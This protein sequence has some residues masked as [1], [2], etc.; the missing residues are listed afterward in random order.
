MLFIESNKNLSPEIEF[1]EDVFNGVHS[2]IIEGNIR[3]IA[4]GLFKDCKT[5]TQIS[6]PPSETK[7]GDYAFSKI[8]I[9]PSVQYIGKE[10]FCD[11][12]SHT[13]ITIPPSLTFIG[14]DA[15]DGYSSLTQI[16]ISPNLE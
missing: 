7:I 4:D 6:I 11:C 2:L 1:G 15:F 10:A 8:S 14:K 13:Q 3:S 9:H 12:F 16:P 5:F